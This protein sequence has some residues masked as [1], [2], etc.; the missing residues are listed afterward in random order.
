MV[1]GLSVKPVTSR[2]V[3]A[4]GSINEGTKVFWGGV[5]KK[6]G[7]IKTR[8]QDPS[9]ERAAHRHKCL[10]NNLKTNHMEVCQN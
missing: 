8:G 3:Q 9:A 1:Y 2:I 6:G 7:F 4:F 10:I 5:C